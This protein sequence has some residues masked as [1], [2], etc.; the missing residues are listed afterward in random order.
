MI[1]RWIQWKLKQ[2]LTEKTHEMFTIYKHLLDL[3]IFIDDSYDTSW[4]L[5]DFLWTWWKKSW[6]FYEILHVNMH[7]IIWRNDS[8]LFWYLLI[9]ILILNAFSKLTHSIML[10]E[11]CSYNIIK[12]MYY[13][14]LFFS[15]ENWMLLNQIT[16]ST[17]RNCLW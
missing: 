15:H 17:I 16:R 12:I 13:I 4:R 8:W 2:L 10:R 14:Q 5:Y 6:S 3:Q 1:S 7:S 9:L 11:M